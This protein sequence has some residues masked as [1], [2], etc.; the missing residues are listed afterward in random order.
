M[1]LVVFLIL[2]FVLFLCFFPPISFLKVQ[3]G[4]Y[5]FRP[6]FFRRSG[7]FINSKPFSSVEGW[8]FQY[9]ELYLVCCSDL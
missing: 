2:G 6:V 1:K 8:Y 9:T 4:F 3:N 7:W 5:N